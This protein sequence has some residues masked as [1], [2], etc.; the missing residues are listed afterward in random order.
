MRES[1]EKSKFKRL[2]LLCRQLLNRGTD[3]GNHSV[4]IRCLLQ[5]RINGNDNQVD[6]R[7]GTSATQMVDSAVARDHGQ[8]GSEAASIRIELLRLVPQLKKDFLQYVFGLR[9]IAQHPQSD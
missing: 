9:G 5:L 4:A 1:L 7:F 3:L 6:I 8:P 2:A